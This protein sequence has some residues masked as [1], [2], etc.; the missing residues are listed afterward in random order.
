[1]LEKLKPGQKAP[2]FL[3][4]DVAGGKVSL[5]AKLPGAAATVVLFICNHCPYVQAYIPRLIALQKDLGVA[6]G[7]GRPAAQLL[8]VC[9]NDAATYPE[10]S[11]DNMKKYA[12]KWGL[13]F[14]YLRDEDQAVARAYGAARTPEIFVLDDGGICRYEGGIDDNYQDA[15]RVTRRPLRDAIVSLSRGEA[16]AE[17]RTYAI[18]CS[19]KWKTA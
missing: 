11:F 1:M 19:I 14:P 16:V 8:A 17:P 12:A 5:S 10:D 6:G 13:N 2:D 7:E 9:A 18:G 15:S 4:P 3:L